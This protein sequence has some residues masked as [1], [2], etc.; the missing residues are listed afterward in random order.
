MLTNSLKIS[1]ATHKD[2]FELM[3]FQI[4]TKMWQ[5]YFHED[6][7]SVSDDLTC[8]L[9]ISILTTDFLGI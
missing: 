4:P 9:S 1:D 6:L 7:D 8:W 2:F 3:L 5:N